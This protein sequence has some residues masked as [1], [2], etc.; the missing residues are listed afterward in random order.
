MAQRKTSKSS[1]SKPSGPTV[2]FLADP[3]AEPVKATALNAPEGA[4]LTGY[5]T[6]SINTP[7]GVRSAVPGELAGPGAAESRWRLSE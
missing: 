7:D 2:L 3:D 5:E 1:T 4:P 6:L